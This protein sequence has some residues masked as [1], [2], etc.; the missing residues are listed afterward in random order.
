MN[1]ILINLDNIIAIGADLKNGYDFL[2]S[3]FDLAD[4]LNDALPGLECAF[5]HLD[6]GNFL[7][8]SEPNVDAQ[9][10][11]ALWAQCDADEMAELAR[12]LES[13]E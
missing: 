12:E 2:R 8:F 13:D 9:R 3:L 6:T 5:T 10:E 11:G 7:A 4:E 1:R